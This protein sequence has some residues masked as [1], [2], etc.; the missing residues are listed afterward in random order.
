MSFKIF[1][2]WRSG[3]PPV[4][5]CKT[6]YAI[7]KETKQNCLCDFGESHHEEQFCE[8][9]LNLSQWFKRKCN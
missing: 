7:L 2:I 9:I 5:W 1:L 3:G 6:I 4:L 8:I